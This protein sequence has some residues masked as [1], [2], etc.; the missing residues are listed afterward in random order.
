MDLGCG[1]MRLAHYC[2]LVMPSLFH[3]IGVDYNRTA[4]ASGIK[5]ISQEQ[6][7]VNF[8]ALQLDLNSPDLAVLDF[9]QEL[10]P[11]FAISKGLQRSALLIDSI[12]PIDICILDSTLCFLSEP[13]YVLD[14]LRP[15]ISEFLITRSISSA[16][17]IGFYSWDGMD[18]FSINRKFSLEYF[19]RYCLTRGLTMKHFQ[20]SLGDNSLYNTVVSITT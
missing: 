20:P 1:N 6:I 8:T 10:T 11:A 19:Q 7:F 4:L 9:T 5:N 2:N 13:L 3:Y 17:E 12:P 18:A 16:D 15:N 14:T